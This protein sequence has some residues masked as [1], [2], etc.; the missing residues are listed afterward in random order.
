VV[1]QVPDE[2]GAEVADIGL[3][4][5]DVL[6]ETVQLGDHDLVT[7]RAAVPVAPGDQRPGHDHDQHSDGADYLGQAC[8]ILH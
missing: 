5:P 7:V 4:F 8:Q 3:N 2:A 6:P 1:F